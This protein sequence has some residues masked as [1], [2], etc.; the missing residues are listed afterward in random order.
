MLL[1]ENAGSLDTLPCRGNLDQNTG[2]VD[3]ELLVKLKLKSVER[4][5]RALRAQMM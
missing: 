1:L 2:L 3:T 4:Y 5:L